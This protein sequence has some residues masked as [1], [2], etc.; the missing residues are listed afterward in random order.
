MRTRTRGRLSCPLVMRVTCGGLVHTAKFQSNSIE[1]ILAHLPGLRVVIPSS[2]KQ[3]YR[4]LLAAIRD[5][6][7]VVF[8]N[9]P[10]FIDP[11]AKT[12][13]TTALALSLIVAWSA[14]RART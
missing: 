7:P 13:P 11:S 9:R 12:S 2:P 6:D 10:A 5:P 14:A 8:S 1:A 3:A 4:L